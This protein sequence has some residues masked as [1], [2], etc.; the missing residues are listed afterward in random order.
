MEKRNTFY[1]APKIPFSLYLLIKNNLRN[2]Q[3]NF[4]LEENL[5]LNKIDKILFNYDID[6]T[7][8]EKSII[9]KILTKINNNGDPY[10]LNKLY[11]LN[12]I[13]YEEVTIYNYIFYNLLKERN[14]K[15]I[16]NTDTDTNNKINFTVGLTD[17]GSVST[18]NI[19]KFNK[20]DDVKKLNYIYD[21]IKYKDIKSRIQSQ[22]ILAKS[23]FSSKINTLT[24]I[25]S[26]K[27]ILY[28]FLKDENFIPKSTYIDIS[29]E[30]ITL[31][32]ILKTFKDYCIANKKDYFVIKP[33]TGTKSDGVGI[34]NIKNLNLEFIK[35]WIF[36]PSNNIYVKGDNL[37]YNTWILS[38][39]VKSFL[40]K[41]NNKL[42]LEKFKIPGFNNSSNFNDQTG[43][44]N[45]FR[46]WC[47]WSIK[48][49]KF[50]S[51]LYKDGYC[52]ISTE[53]LKEYKS[54]E[55]NPENLDKYYQDYYKIKNKDGK[56]YTKRELA[57]EFKNILNKKKLKKK[58]DIEEQKIE[59]ATI[60]SY[61]DF[62]YIINENN[63]P[64]GKKN[65]NLVIEEMKKLINS[66]IEKLKKYLSCIN[67]YN[68]DFNERGC[69]SYFALDI[70]IDENNKPWLLETNSRPF[71]GFD[72]WWN[73]YDK[74]NEHILNVKDFI[75]SIL[76]ITIDT[77]LSSERKQNKNYNKFIITN[78]FVLK[79]TNNIYV[80]LSLGINI[81]STA[82]VYNFIYDILEKNNYTSFPYPKYSK[83]INDV[84]AFRGISPISKYLIY[85]ISLLGNDKFLE[86]MKYLFPF[87]AK[88]KVLNRIATLGFYLGDKAVMTNKL[89]E[90]IKNWNTIIPS[91]ITI[92]DKNIDINILNQNF[93]IDEKIIAKPA[94]GQQGRDIIIDS[95][96]EKIIEFINKSNEQNWVISKYLDNPFLIKLKK[97]KNESGIEY[98]DKKGRKAHLRAYVLVYRSKTE[99]K[100]YLYKNS[101]IFCAAE[102]YDKNT[103]YSN[104]TNLY[105]GSKY[106]S[107]ILKK[108]PSY[109]YKDLSIKV[110]DYFKDDI[111]EELIKKI[112]ISINTTI[113]AVKDNLLCLN[114][115]NICFQY[116][117]FD[118]HLE[119]NNSKPQPWL[120]EVNS[121]PGLKAPSYQ[122]KGGIKNFLESILN[123]TINTKMSS[124]NQNLFEELPNNLI[125]LNEV[126]EKILN[127]K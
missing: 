36:N 102:E 94:Q 57:F 1:I 25:L 46:F 47:L 91:S 113:Y 43:R 103:E 62:A 55:L 70:I 41:L 24:A 53:E 123:I 5:I 33:S 37:Y 71:V 101:L 65:W 95:N 99:L 45:K 121:T 122:W 12:K 89:K 7:D 40:Y 49:N 2:E 110:S 58:L 125:E 48:N 64:N 52:E 22:D 10:F 75:D 69:F 115:N 39:F 14:Y 28:S 86:I 27:S 78:S 112:K 51:Y 93:L 92:K 108:D 120:L 114:E 6:F 109:A 13:E 96:K 68:E 26:N 126:E 82:N 66:I 30:D 60:G 79:D 83:N 20:L 54:N 107:D 104:L 74:D 73:E 31:K 81:T 3:L 124:N 87:D 106:Y 59:A 56:Q 119:D 80:P 90:N 88:V 18:I 67:K 11:F 77:T 76:N 21:L 19:Y 72:D 38:F 15:Q 61:L 29:M 17:I 117:A 105:Y 32:N 9:H 127:F 100:N 84:I 118:F 42:T 4:T 34:F 8:D 97:E 85:K 16:I 98:D 35:S 111:Y 44:I 116:I 50:T 23:Q 63:Y